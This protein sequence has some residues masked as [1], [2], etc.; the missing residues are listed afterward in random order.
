MSEYHTFLGIDIGKY[1]VVVAAHGFP[2]TQTFANTKEGFKSFLKTYRKTLAHAFVVLETTGGYEQ[3]FLNTLLD[4]DIHVH[5]ANTRQVKS[6]IRSF[7]KR[8]KT[9]ALDAQALALYG[10]ERH[11]TLSL[12]TKPDPTLLQL[13]ALVGRRQDLTQMLVA[14]KNRLKA[15]HNPPVI[16]QSCQKSIQFINQQIEALSKEIEALI[17][18]NPRLYAQ[19]NF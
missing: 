9:D 12:W 4:H 11:K 17:Q 10:F 6:F 3:L 15:P 18:E 7:G 5:R 8:G 16:A 13:S 2:S 19:K 1:E 14:E